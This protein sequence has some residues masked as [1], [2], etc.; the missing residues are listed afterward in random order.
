[1]SKPRPATTIEEATRIWHEHMACMRGQ[2]KIIADL[3][4]T[5]TRITSELE[6][7]RKEQQ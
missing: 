5:I 4:A 6:Q 3:R 1:M 2:T 7:L